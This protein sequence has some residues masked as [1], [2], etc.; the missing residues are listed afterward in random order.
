MVELM[1]NVREI[2]K[3]SLELMLKLL[4]DPDVSDDDKVF[5]LTRSVRAYLVLAEPEMYAF[6]SECEQKRLVRPRSMNDDPPV[7]S[8]AQAHKKECSKYA[9]D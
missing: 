2:Y 7:I 4:E 3:T 8:K 6:C 1:V 5:S 9:V